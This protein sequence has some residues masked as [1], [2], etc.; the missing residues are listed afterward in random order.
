MYKDTLTKTADLI[1][2]VSDDDST[3]FVATISPNGNT[4]NATFYGD[5][6]KMVKLLTSLVK[7]ADQ[8]KDGAVLR[9]AFIEVFSKGILEVQ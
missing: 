9:D 3:I 4:G 7:L 1:E 8:R 2:Q 6:P 5:A